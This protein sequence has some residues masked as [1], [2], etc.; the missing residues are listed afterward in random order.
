MT[1]RN[2]VITFLFCMFSIFAMCSCSD[3][4]SRENIYQGIFQ[5]G[6]QYQNDKAGQY[7][8]AD[9]PSNDSYQDYKESRQDT[10]QKNNN[11][12]IQTE[13]QMKQL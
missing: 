1:I 4:N 10:L 13:E 11:D 9:V 7:P 8:L 3:P 2:Q 5:F 12:V 6:Q